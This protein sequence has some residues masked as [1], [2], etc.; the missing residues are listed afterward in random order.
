MN[1]VKQC[2]VL[3]IIGALCTSI[4]VRAAVDGDKIGQERFATHHS[5]SLEGE[6]PWF[7]L[8]L[9]ANL[10][11]ASRRSDFADFRVFD[12][13]GR[14]MPFSLL[15]LQTE[16][17]TAET[18]RE[19]AIFPLFS[20]S[21]SDVN[22]LPSVK[23]E[24]NARGTLIEVIPDR[25][26]NAVPARVRRGW[27]L[28]ASGVEGAMVSLKLDWPAAEQTASFHRFSVESSDDLQRWRKLA[29]GQIV[30]M[31]FNGAL[32]DQREIRLPAVR[33]RYLRL[34][35]QEPEQ[36]P[37]L[38]RVSVMSRRTLSQ[39]P[40]LSWSDSVWAE[41]SS[42]GDYR[43]ILPR[44]LAVEH[45][46]VDLPQINTLSPIQ[47]SGGYRDRKGREVWSELGEGLIY[48]LAV[49][50]QEV[51]QNNIALSPRAYDSFRLRADGLDMSRLKVLFGLAP[52]RLVFL[53][54][55]EAPYHLSLGN[56]EALSADLPIESLMPPI[57][58]HTP[59]AGVAQVG[60]QLETLLPVI[61]ENANE[62]RE[63]TESDWKR[64]I[65]WG[66][67]FVGV[68]LLIMMTVH[69]LRGSK[70]E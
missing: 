27:L 66:V 56:E 37:M 67:L 3:L 2:A 19:V 35:W 11:M 34:I 53:A 6:G 44:V 12:A 42:E 25:G 10:R 14:A 60:D 41:R 40:P 13:K 50:G 15:R 4:S 8:D 47:V 36:A 68:A 70:Q 46:R 63:G 58:G 69:I 57:A 23:L 55:G 43:V 51:V 20:E 48:R 26:A 21:E 9:P 16:Y 28:D 29:D 45:I 54:R 7:Q 17:R 61:G 32:I 33:S 1:S 18:L 24:S 31:S 52:M 5:L 38:Q 64:F 62:S 22:P 30:R 59:Q 49:G 65:L 39:S